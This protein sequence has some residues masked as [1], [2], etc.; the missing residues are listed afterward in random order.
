MPWPTPGHRCAPVAAGDEKAAPFTS[1]KTATAAIRVYQLT[2]KMNRSRSSTS[3]SSIGSSINKSGL[4]PRTP[5]Q[6]NQQVVIPE[7]ENEGVLKDVK[8]QVM[9]DPTAQVTKWLTERKLEDA[10]YW[11]TLATTR[12]EELDKVLEENSKMKE[13]LEL[14]RC[15]NTQLL[16]IV[17][18]VF[19]EELKEDSGN[20]TIDPNDDD[21]LSE[22]VNTP[23]V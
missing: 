13:E 6:L 9:S 1:L 3:R 19:A 18:R 11:K 15:E 21:Y 14:L 8:E 23:G 16:E 17:G 2:F 20:G 22:P 7:K 12:K 4:K 10:E 5:S